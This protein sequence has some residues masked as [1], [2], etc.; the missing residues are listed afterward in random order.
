MS[1]VRSRNSYVPL[2]GV[3]TICVALADVEAFAGGPPRHRRVGVGLHALSRPFPLRSS[4][5]LPR[6]VSQLPVRR[7]Q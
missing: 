1:A 2:V 4:S 6:A 3:T 7:P 5:T